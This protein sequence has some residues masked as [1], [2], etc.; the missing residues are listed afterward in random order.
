MF[1]QKTENPECLFEVKNISK[2]NICSLEALLSFTDVNHL[3]I[4]VFNLSIEEIFIPA[5]SQFGAI[6][7]CEESF[8]V[9]HMNFSFD[10]TFSVPANNLEQLEKDSYLD[11]DEKEQPVIDY[12]KTGTYTKFMSQEIKDS[13][14]VT[15]MKLQKMNVWTDQGFKQQFDSDH[16]PSKSSNMQ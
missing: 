4:P 7:I 5:N 2:P 6:E 3:N 11:E 16:L 12:L 14:S 15:E 1:T 8:E 13:P 10:Q 9:F